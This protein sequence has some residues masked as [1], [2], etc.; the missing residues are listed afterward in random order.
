[1]MING[2]KRLGIIILLVIILFI[3][4]TFELHAKEKI[5]PNENTQIIYRLIEGDSSLTILF[6]HGLGENLRTWEKIEH[7]ID[8]HAFKSVGID[9]ALFALSRVSNIC[10]TYKNLTKLSILVTL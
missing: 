2:K 6:L 9:S 3:L 7:Q 1:M 5:G 10:N 4:I 8:S